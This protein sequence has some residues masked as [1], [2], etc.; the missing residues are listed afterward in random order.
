MIFIAPVAYEERLAS[1]F[2]DTEIF[3]LRRIQKGEDGKGIENFFL[4]TFYQNGATGVHPCN[5][6]NISCSRRN[7]CST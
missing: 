7:Y 3:E 6:T 2:A 1:R 5:R 4:E